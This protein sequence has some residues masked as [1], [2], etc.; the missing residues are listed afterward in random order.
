MKN[1]P[2]INKIKFIS[3]EG[4]EVVVISRN[5]LYEKADINIS[6]LD[7]DIFKEALKGE[8]YYSD[9]YFSKSENEM[10]INISKNVQDINTKDTIGVIIFE[11]SLEGFHEVISSKL[12][13]GNGIAI[14]NINNNSFLYKSSQF[15]KFDENIILQDSSRYEVRVIALHDVEYLLVSS[16]YKYSRLEL[17]FFLINN[18]QNI[19]SDIT[20]TFNKNIILLM[21]SIVL[22][23]L[24]MFVFI[25]YSLKPLKDLTKEIQYL[26]NEIDE[27]KEKKEKAT[28]KSSDEIIS[29]KSSFELFAKLI[30]KEREKLQQLNENLEVR[31]KE[32]VRKNKENQELLAHQ[33]K[34]AS[35]GEMIGNIAHQ[36]RQPLSVISTIA[37]GVKFRKEFGTLTDEEIMPE[38]DTIVSQSQYLSKTIDDF[39]NF[40]KGDSKKSEFSIREVLEQV[41]SLIG[42]SLKNNY[43]ELIT[44]LEDDIQIDGYENELIQAFINIFNN[45]KDV[46]KSNVSENEVRL[47]FVTTQKT[48][49]GIEIFIKDNGGGIDA[50]VLPRI[51]EPY[52]TTKH[53]SVGTGIGLTMVY[54]IIEE[55][56][57]GKVKAYN[58]EFEYN[59]KRYK[60]ACFNILFKQLS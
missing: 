41:M 14:Y 28:E 7:K 5:R 34:M 16:D 46:L 38:M 33:A 37:S 39:K 47:I 11:V 20:K 56:H 42:S 18:T 43:I 49:N 57:E 10:M 59:G 60:G 53:Q 55:R 27:E 19:F 3:L 48:D 30:F 29:I 6:Y 51:F 22:V 52:F 31:V 54:Q 8:I 35:M 45:S 58:E 24:I 36:W 26:T 32:E 15:D 17:K 12:T 25:S 50:E 23:A 4:K 2:Q 40:I 44:D 1:I 21:F 13:N 9:I